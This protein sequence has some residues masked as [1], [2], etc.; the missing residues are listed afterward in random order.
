MPQP[1]LWPS[2]D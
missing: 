2:F 1:P